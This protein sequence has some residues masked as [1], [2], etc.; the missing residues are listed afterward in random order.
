MFT[1]MLSEKEAIG[2]DAI[3]TNDGAIVFIY[4]TNNGKVFKKSLDCG[5]TFVESWTVNLGKITANSNVIRLIDGRWMMPLKNK[6]KNTL[7]AEMLGADFTVV[8][9]SD[10]G[11]TWSGERK[12]NEISGCYYLMNARLLRLKSGRILMPLCYH[13]D[14]LLSKEYFENKGYSGCYFT[15]DEGQTWQHGTWIKGNIAQ[16]MLAEPMVIETDGKVLMYMRTGTGYLYMSE[17]KDGGE[18]FSEERP[19][20]LR[21]PNAPFAVA[22]DKYSGKIFAVWD[23]AFP[24]PIHQYPR[25]PICMA[26]SSNGNDWDF[27]ME[28]DNNPMHNYGYPALY[29]TKKEIIVTYYYNES[30]RF[31]NQINQIKLKII[32]RKNLKIRKYYYEKLF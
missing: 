26:V 10:E 16:G 13:P 31:N 9:S 28:L 29:F 15:D 1:R 14:E 2:S 17:S 11:K 24:S 6:P 25:S 4:S 27:I 5:R 32:D 8:F 7:A 3:K 20:S 21:S 19:T 30:R 22:K 18:T 23:N 12:V